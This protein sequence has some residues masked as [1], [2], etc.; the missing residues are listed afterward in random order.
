LAIAALSGGGVDFDEMLPLTV[1][2]LREREQ[3]QG[4]AR[5]V[6]DAWRNE[7]LQAAQRLQNSRGQNDSWGNHKRRLIAL[8]ELYR[9]VLN[10]A[11]AADELMHQIKHLPDGFAGYQAPAKLRLAD[12][13]RACRMVTPNTLAA[14]LDDALSSAHHIQD[15][16]FCARITARCNALQRWHACDW[17]GDD[18]ANTIQAL[19][20]SPGDPTF[21]ADHVVHETYRYRRDDQDMLPIDGAHDA[22]TLEQLA[23]VFQRP[24]VE[25]RR[26]NLFSLS[27]VLEDQTPIRIPDPGFTPLLAMHLAAR[28]LADDALDDRRTVLL[29]SLIPVA[30]INPTALDTVLSYLLIAAEPDEDMLE[31]IAAEVGE[32]KF[33]DVAAPAGQI[34]PDST[35]PS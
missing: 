27:D 4:K 24:A 2:T 10:D 31:D 21:A 20:K 7:A 34:G 33:N 16:H 11:S 5:T 26:L 30:A 14:A 3:S 6:I 25:F 23:E 19:A 1:A 8:M 18:L 9:L 13:M 35:M 12:A 29:R 32:V 22:N 17:Q 28:V 15:Y